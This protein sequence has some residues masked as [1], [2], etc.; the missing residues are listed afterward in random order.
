MP[1]AKGRPGGAERQRNARLVRGKKPDGLASSIRV[2]SVRRSQLC[3]VPAAVQRALRSPSCRSISR[4]FQPLPQ[5]DGGGQ[6]AD[7]EA[8]QRQRTQNTKRRPERDRPDDGGVRGGDAEDQHGNSQ[9]QGENRKQ[10]TAAPHWN[11]ERRSRQ[12]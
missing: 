8:Y 9:R 12:G 3:P 5:R 4:L 7:D 11:R 1:T 6:R 10:E 2:M